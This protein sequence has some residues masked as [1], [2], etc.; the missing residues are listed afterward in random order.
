[1]KRSNPVAVQNLRFQTTTARGHFRSLRKNRPRIKISV[2][3]EFMKPIEY[4]LLVV[5]VSLCTAATLATDVAIADNASIADHAGAKAA[6]NAINSTAGSLLHEINQ[7]KIVETTAN[8]SQTIGFGQSSQNS[9]SAAENLAAPIRKAE[10]RL[11]VQSA[12]NE[13]KTSEN[14]SSQNASATNAT[15]TSKTSDVNSTA[16]KN[17]KKAEVA[18]YVYNDDDDSLDVSLYIDSVPKGKADVSKGKE[19]TFGNFTLDQGI[20][21]FKIIWKDEDTNKVYESE[22]KKEI[23]GDDVVSLYTTAHTEPEKYDLTVSVKNENDKSTNAYLY[24]DGIYQDRKEISEDST[25]DFSSA[26]VEEGVHD[27]SLTWLDPYTNDQYEKTKRV[28]IEGDSAVV[29]IAG[30][31]TSF[32]DLGKT[33][34]TTADTASSGSSYFSSTSSGST[35]S[36]NSQSTISEASNNRTTSDSENSS[37]TY[38]KAE[39]SDSSAENSTGNSEYGANAHDDSIV[40]NTA[41]DEMKG[42]GSESAGTQDAAKAGAPYSFRTLGMIDSLFADKANSANGAEAKSGGWGN[43]SLVYILVLVGAAYLVIRH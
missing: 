23:N 17:A 43:I 2:V 7:S 24:I 11:T 28:T 37:G 20:H 10:T 1:M 18:A 19:E 33:V 40:N 29:F 30:K 3:W 6:E 13:T 9:S 15:E 41:N 14:F 25:N 12:D 35:N 8:D 21:R 4:L 39:N 16:S 34:E 42:T 22:I 5:L 31:G 26:S 36:S 32:Q 38:G 27:V